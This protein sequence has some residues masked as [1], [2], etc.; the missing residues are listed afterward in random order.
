MQN[1]NRQLFRSQSADLIIQTGHE[2][3]RRLP[4]K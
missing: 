4:T 3:I 1:D 2:K